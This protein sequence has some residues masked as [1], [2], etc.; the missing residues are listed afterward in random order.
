MDN[1][2]GAS[3]KSEAVPDKRCTFKSPNR[4]KLSK[5]SMP[6]ESSEAVPCPSSRRKHQNGRNSRSLQEPALAVQQRLR[7]TQDSSKG[8]K[9]QTRIYRLPLVVSLSVR[10]NNSASW[11]CISLGSLYRPARPRKTLDQVEDTISNIK[12][13]KE[14]R[15]DDLGKLKCVVRKSQFL[16]QDDQIVRRIMLR[17]CYQNHFIQ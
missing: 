4:S 17:K 8:Q 16:T 14:K 3:Q 5:S 11:C 12:I 1:R 10:T 13:C 6:S 15:R 9:V 2:V 7:T